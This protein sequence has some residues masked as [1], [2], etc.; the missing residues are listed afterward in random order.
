[1]A[2]SKK[3]DWCETAKQLLTH[4]NDKEKVPIKNSKIVPLNVMDPQFINDGRELI[5][6]AINE[7]FKNG[8]NGELYEIFEAYEHADEN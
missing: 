5:I 4:M 1:M 6:K 3:K 7:E 2:A 8:I